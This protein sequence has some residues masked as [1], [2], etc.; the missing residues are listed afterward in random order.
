L[1]VILDPTHERA[2]DQ[3]KTAL[4]PTALVWDCDGEL[5]SED[6]DNLIERLRLQELNRQN[7]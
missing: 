7:H 5:C 6:L 1:L 4:T 3:D 2:V